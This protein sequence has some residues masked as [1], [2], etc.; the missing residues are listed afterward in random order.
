MTK[1]ELLNK[2]LQRVANLYEVVIATRKAM[3][4]VI[5]QMNDDNI[6]WSLGDKDNLG[7]IINTIDTHYN[8]VFEYT[9]AVNSLKYHYEMMDTTKL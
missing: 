7:I 5:V 3:D 2:Q 6:K 9:L 4:I 1:K 8:V